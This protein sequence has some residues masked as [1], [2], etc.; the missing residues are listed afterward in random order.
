MTTRSGAC[1]A[2]SPS[3]LLGVAERRD[4]LVP[5]VG[6]EAARAPRAGAP[7]PRRSRPAR[8]LRD[9]RRSGAAVALDLERPAARRD[10]IREPAAGRSPA[11]A[12]RRRCRR[13]RR[14]TTSRP[15]SRAAHE[16][17]PGGV[18]VLHGVREPLAGDEVGGRLDPAV[19][20]LARAL[21]STGIGARAPARGAPGRARRRAGT[22]GGR[23]RARA[24]RRSRPR[25][26]RR[27]RRASARPD[28]PRWSRA[29]AA[30][31]AARG[32]SR[33]AAAGR[34]R[35]DRARSAGAPRSPAATIRA[36]EA[37]LGQ[38]AAKLDP[39]ARD[40]DRKAAGL[41]DRGSR[42]GCSSVRRPWSTTAERLA[43]ALD[44]DRSA[45]V[46]GQRRRRARRGVDVQLA[47]GQVEQELERRIGRG[48]RAAPPRRLGSRAA[49]RS[50]RGTPTSAGSAS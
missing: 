9:Q 43:A 3:S 22:G 47:L 14:D 26:R 21:T 33:R 44:R 50:R 2:T 40:L 49:G 7:G 8:Q 15:F 24:A 5:A 36:R 31:A 1:S 27:R 11:P 30:R 4:D 37:Y 23:A 6:E 28:P 39:Q 38:L 10:A 20:A 17:D 34:R 25:P 42:L 29:R 12:R 19:E 32:R 41:D 35:G 16:I 45:A 46:A 48:R 18:C 13:R